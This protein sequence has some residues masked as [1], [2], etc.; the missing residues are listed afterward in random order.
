MMP[1][2][3]TSHNLIDSHKQIPVVLGTHTITGFECGKRSKLR[4]PYFTN[5]SLHKT[6]N[7]LFGDKAE[8]RDVKGCRSGMRGDCMCHGEKGGLSMGV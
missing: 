6:N 4:S 5:M 3:I 7:H 1:V 2:D 8:R